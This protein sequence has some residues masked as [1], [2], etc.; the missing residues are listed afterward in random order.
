[1]NITFEEFLQGIRHY[2]ARRAK[3]GENLS[4]PIENNESPFINTANI[5]K[6]GS[7]ED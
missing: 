7:T 4:E 3:F 5:D 6:E 2:A 1:M